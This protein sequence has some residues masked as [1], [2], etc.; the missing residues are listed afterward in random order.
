MARKRL[1]NNKQRGMTRRMRGARTSK[2]GM[3]N[4]LQKIKTKNESQNREKF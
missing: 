2:K 4:P 1:K 3:R